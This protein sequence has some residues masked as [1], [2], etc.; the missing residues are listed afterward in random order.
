MN[1]STAITCFALAAATSLVAKD[2]SITE[3]DQKESQSF[4]WR[5]VDDGVM[6]GL[7]KGKISITDNGILKFD[8]KLS[9]ENNGGFSSLRS[10][11]IQLNLSK[12]DGLLARV[13]G[14][15]RSYQVRLGTDETFRGMEV[16]FMAEFAT[17][18]GQ[19]TEVK[20]P[21]NQLS[22]SFR[23]MQLEDRTFDSSLVTRIGLLLGDKKAGPFELQVDWIHAYKDGADSIVDLAIADGRFKTLATALTKAGLVDTLKDGGPFTV[24]APTDD[25]F[26]KLPDATVENILKPENL[27]QLQSVLKY[28][29]TSG[30]IDLPAALSAGEATTLQG[31]SLKIAF[32]NGQVLVG[33][34]AIR[35]ADIKASNGVIH[36]ID[37]VLLPPAPP[38]PKTLLQIAQADGRFTTLLAAIKAAGLTSALEEK[39]PLTVFAPT[40]EAFAKLP[41]GTLKGLLKHEKKD[42]LKAILALHA[43]SGKVSAGDALNSGV[44][45]ALSGGD[46][47]FEVKGGLL[48]VN[49]ATIQQ[50]D[51]TVGNGVIHVIDTVLLPASSKAKKEG[52]DKLTAG[53]TLEK[54]RK[55]VATGVPIFNHGRHDECAKI[56]EASLKDLISSDALDESLSSDLKKLIN[57][58]GKSDATARAWIYR[59]GL[60]HAHQALE[61]QRG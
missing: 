39:G 22:A 57:R 58:A 49:D 24:F 25:A 17:T 7:S 37:T 30:S 2:L 11:D 23:G 6:G 5:V 14:D 18:K 34:A 50:T 32:E 38:A 20:I 44:T 15:G 8:G 9:L 48:K 52:G 29:V 33:D 26:A 51:I 3:F 19:W 4:D 12:Y 36:V 1:V 56:Y 42:Q 45:T 61:Q 16:S 43:V 54:I 47:R 59:R 28:H 35:D 46:L 53:L 40:D 41:K 10:K 13:R 27:D 55:A 60:D 21:F 31:E